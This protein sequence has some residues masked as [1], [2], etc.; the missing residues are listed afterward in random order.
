MVNLPRHYSDEDSSPG[1]KQ[2][3]EWRV[4]LQKTFLTEDKSGGEK[5]TKVAAE[6]V[7]TSDSKP[8]LY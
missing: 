5:K 8:S 4:K 6:K 1:A 2:C 7:R 3:R